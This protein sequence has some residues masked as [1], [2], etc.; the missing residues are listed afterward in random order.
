[1]EQLALG[2]KGKKFEAATKKKMKMQLSS[3]DW[4]FLALVYEVLT[5][6]PRVSG[7]PESL[8][9]YFQPFH[10]ITLSLSTA[11]TPT[12]SSILPFYKQLEIHLK[13]MRAQPDTAEIR[14]GLDRAIAKLDVHMKKALAGRYP[15]LGAGTLISATSNVSH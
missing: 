4:A 3:A 5:I 13:K 11:G 10:K 6:C 9:T 12:I 2:L 14:V 8:T 1:M 7:A 15:L